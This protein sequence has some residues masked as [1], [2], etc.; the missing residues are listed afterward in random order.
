M[1]SNGSLCCPLGTPRDVFLIM[2]PYLGKPGGRGEERGGAYLTSCLFPAGR[3]NPR[4]RSGFLT[5]S[6]KKHDFAYVVVQFLATILILLSFLS[7][8]T[9]N[10]NVADTG[11]HF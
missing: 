9:K 4:F 6:S 2:A 8:L 11:F 1:A 5:L 7:L 3:E 10:N